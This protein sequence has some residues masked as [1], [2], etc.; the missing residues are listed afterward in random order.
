MSAIPN[1][2]SLEESLTH[3]LYYRDDF[4]KETAWLKERAF[5][6]PKKSPGEISFNGAC[7]MSDSKQKKL[8]KEVKRTSSTFGGF[9]RMSRQNL[10]NV[11]V[12]LIEKSAI[13]PDTWVRLISFIYLFLSATI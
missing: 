3:A 8:A 2:I 12:Y 10:K 1:H 13:L 6:P 7:Y 9:V 11:L 4:S 5:R